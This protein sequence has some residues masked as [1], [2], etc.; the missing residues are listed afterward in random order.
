MLGHIMGLPELGHF[1]K[2]FLLSEIFLAA[3]SPL[4]LQRSDS[5][6]LL[7]ARPFGSPSYILVALCII[8][9]GQLIHLNLIILLGF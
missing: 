7:L 6:D 8:A 9:L 2:W 1:N 5:P 3:Q 4:I